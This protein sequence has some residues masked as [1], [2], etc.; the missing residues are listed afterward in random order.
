MVNRFGES[1]T[2]DL[3]RGRK[4]KG[5]SHLQRKNGGRGPKE[6]RKEGS[7][8]GAAIMTVISY[9]TLGRPSLPKSS[10]GAAAAAALASPPPS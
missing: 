1:R 4:E 8:R 9:R 2:M 5:E 7:P 3:I 10:R 6:G